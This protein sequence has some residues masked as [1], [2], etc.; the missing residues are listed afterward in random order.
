[1]IHQIS[2][3][4]L[5]IIRVKYIL[6][7]TNKISLGRFSLKYEILKKIMCNMIPYKS[8]V[9][10]AEY[11]ILDVSPIKHSINAYPRK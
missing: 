6:A 5:W 7:S 3:G 2:F 11:C 10:Y 1:M 8:K 4:E 9:I